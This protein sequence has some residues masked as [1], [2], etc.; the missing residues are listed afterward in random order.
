MMSLTITY[1][2]GALWEVW[3]DVTRTHTTYNEQGGVVSVEP[4]TPEE[5][6]AADAAAAEA[7]AE[8]AAAALRAAVKQI[9][10][11]LQAEKVR[12]D[13]VIAKSN[14]SITGADT[15]DVA[16]ASK[17]IADAAIDLARV[18]QNL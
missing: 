15:K 9:V 8:A 16:R 2:N 7:A 1:P 13:A 14:A 5:N 6:A 12:L 4:Y 10:T 18:V 11:D 3:D 17:R